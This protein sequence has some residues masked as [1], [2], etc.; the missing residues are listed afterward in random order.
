MVLKLGDC[1]KTA[2][3]CDRALAAF[4]GAVSKNRDERETMLDDTLTDSKRKTRGVCDGTTK[5]RLSPVK[6]MNGA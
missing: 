2:D 3:I 5:D 6:I 4:G 1:Y